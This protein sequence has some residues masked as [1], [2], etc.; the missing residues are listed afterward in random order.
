MKGEE[1]S[2]ILHSS[3]YILSKI[4]IP[5][6]VLNRAAYSISECLITVGQ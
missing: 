1:G 4:S 3:N 2:P 6:L 5:G